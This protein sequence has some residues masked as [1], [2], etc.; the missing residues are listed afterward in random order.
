[1][2]QQLVQNFQDHCERD[3]L[4]LKGLIMLD[5][6]VCMTIDNLH[7]RRSG[8]S[9]I[10]LAPN[11]SLL[12]KVQG[13]CNFITDVGVLKAHAAD[14]RHEKVHTAKSYT[15]APLSARSRHSVATEASV[16]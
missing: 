11:I 2:G 12:A 3:L 1:M 14:L 9:S 6:Q 8:C 10:R 7:E 15:A 13:L 5:V 16:A 4:E